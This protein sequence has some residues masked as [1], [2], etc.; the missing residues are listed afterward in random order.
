MIAT[1]SSKQS[2]A[3]IES[4]AS[5]HLP[6]GLPGLGGLLAAADA[7]DAG[8]LFVGEGGVVAGVHCAS[9]GASSERDPWARRSRQRRTHEAPASSAFWMSSRRPAVRWCPP[10]SW[11]APRGCAAPGPPTARSPPAAS[12]PDPCRFVAG[13]EARGSSAS[14]GQKLI[15]GA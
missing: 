14:A 11:P 13:V 12:R 10:G 15:A 3:A 8:E 6:A 2:S 1:G 7:G 4:V 9:A 5:D